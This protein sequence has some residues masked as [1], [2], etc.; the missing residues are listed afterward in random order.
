M[1]YDQLLFEFVMTVSQGKN[2]ALKMLSVK[3]EY[4][5]YKLRI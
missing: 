3:T 4:S 1:S 5:T 2:V